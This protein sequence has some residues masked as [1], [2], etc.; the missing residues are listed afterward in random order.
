MKK[1]LIFII[2]CFW[3]ILLL[4]SCGGNFFNPRYYY[5][6][7]E[8]QDYVEING[9]FTDYVS[10]KIFKYRDT[11]QW[12]S[13]YPLDDSYSPDVRSL[14]LK[15]YTFSEG[16]KTLE[17]KEETWNK[18]EATKTTSYNLTQANDKSASYTGNGGTISLGINYSG[19]LVQNDTVVGIIA[20]SFVDNGPI[21]P[22]RVRGAV[23]K[24]GYIIYTFNEDGTSLTLQFKYLF[25]I[26]RHTYKLVRLDNDISMNYTGIYHDLDWWTQLTPYKRLKLNKD[27]NDNTI[28]SS[29]Q[30]GIINGL[31]SADSD[32]GLGIKAY[33]VIR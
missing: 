25:S 32:F 11:S 13:S 33:R 31:G 24:D 5:N 14:I 18:P 9:G 15:T 20:S 6:K 27:G 26:V 10:S 12:T 7:K 17:I 3:A 8:R 29:T 1:I 16:G 23:F 4:S 2:Y 22:D 30:G 28:V 19:N 21:F